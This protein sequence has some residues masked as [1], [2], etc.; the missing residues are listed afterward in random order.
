L[1][2]GPTDRLESSFWG[3]CDPSDGASVA[4]RRVARNRHDRPSDR[5]LFM[6]RAQAFVMRALTIRNLVDRERWLA[7]SSTR[8]MPS[9]C[10]PPALNAGRRWND[11][12]GRCGAQPVIKRRP[13]NAL[14]RGKNRQNSFRGANKA[15]RS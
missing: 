6:P 5:M 3:V 11:A 9:P 1:V 14:R 4:S 12:F 2:G 8:C 10:R 15:G 13:S 7:P